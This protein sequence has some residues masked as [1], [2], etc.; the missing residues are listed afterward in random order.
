LFSRIRDIEDNSGTC[1]RIS[2]RISLSITPAASTVTL[3]RR[4]LDHHP[5]VRLS[6]YGAEVL[7]GFIMAARLSVPKPLPDETT[8]SPYPAHFQLDCDQGTRVLIEQ[9]D[10]FPLS[11]DARLWDRL[12]AELCLV[13]AHGREHSQQHTYYAVA[14]LH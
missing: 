5:S 10:R 2:L 3:E 13:L 11:I 12:Y 7:N 1:L 6:L 14:S 8:G 9:E 4:D